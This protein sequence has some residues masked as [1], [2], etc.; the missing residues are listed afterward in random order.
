MGLNNI[1]SKST[2]GQAASDINTNFTTID[3]D[4]KK[5]KNATTRN[6]GYFSTSSE[7]ISAFPT[8]SKGD[9][10]YVGSSYPYDIWKWNGGSWAKSG[11]TGGEESV[12]LGNYYTKVE[13]DEKFTEAD[14]KLSELSEEISGLRTETDQKLSELGSEVRRNYFMIGGY[15]NVDYSTRKISIPSAFYYNYTEN[16]AR[17]PINA[18]ELTLLEGS[19][20][21]IYYDIISAEYKVLSSAEINNYGVKNSYLFVAI[22]PDNKNRY[23]ISEVAIAYNRIVVNRESNS[24]FCTLAFSSD[25]KITIRDNDIIIPQ[26]A[27]VVCSNT[28]YSVG[29]TATLT[30]TTDF[31]YV[32]YNRDDNTFVIKTGVFSNG[33][34]EFVVFAFRKTNGVIKIYGEPSTTDDVEIVNLCSKNQLSI[35]TGSQP[36]LIDTRRRKIHFGKILIFNY[37]GEYNIVKMA[38]DYIL[39]YSLDNYSIRYIYVKLDAIANAVTT[40]SL[41]GVF[42]VTKNVTNYNANEYLIA[43]LPDSSYQNN[44]RPYAIFDFITEYEKNRTAVV[45]KS[46]ETHIE[47]V[48]S[49]KSSDGDRFLDASAYDQFETYIN[50]FDE[51]VDKANRINTYITKCWI[52]GTPFDNS[53]RCMSTM[54][55]SGEHN[56]RNDMKLYPLIMYKFRPREYGEK[57]SIKTIRRKIL[58]VSGIHGGSSGGDHWESPVAWYYVA[59]RIVELFYESEQFINIRNNFDIDLIPCANPWGLNNLQRHCGNGTD[60][61]RDFSNFTTNESTFIRDLIQANSYDWAH[62]SHCLGGTSLT[63]GDLATYN[64]FGMSDDGRAYMLLQQLNNYIMAKYNSQVATIAMKDDTLSKFMDKYAKIGSSSEIP[65]NCPMYWGDTV[66]DV[67]S[68]EVVKRCV[69]YCQNLISIF[70]NFIMDI[71]I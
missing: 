29:H 27:V 49:L 41:E 60:I 37:R 42:H 31:G 35:A 34:H 56:P 43:T 18:T 33:I 4:L 63:S 64:Y 2:W 46:F 61:N 9:I 67:H 5:V 38:N 44:I 55:T 25:T 68:S 62:D 7:L 59:K 28:R 15:I 48:K 39:D 3:S 13:T 53:N 12:N 22:I 11:S 36:I 21:N 6:K 45:A 71:N 69:D 51:L 70:C 47:S 14:A 57:E 52:D 20:S 30:T 17:I 23:P 32:V 8:A 24:G 40:G 19:V 10:A 66:G 26:T 16:T 50:Q 65:A 54:P 58:I 1:N